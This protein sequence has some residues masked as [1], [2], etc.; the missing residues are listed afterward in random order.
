MPVSKLKKSDKIE[1]EDCPICYNAFHKEE[2]VYRPLLNG[3]LG[4]RYHKKCLEEWC[5]KSG[6]SCVD[7]VTTIKFNIL[8]SK[9]C[10]YSRSY[11]ITLHIENERIL[12]GTEPCDQFY[13][14]KKFISAQH[15]IPMEFMTLY[16]IKGNERIPVVESSFIGD[17]LELELAISANMDGFV[18]DDNFDYY[19][20]YDYYDKKD[21][22]KIEEIVKDLKEIETLENMKHLSPQ[23]ITTAAKQAVDIDESSPSF[24]IEESDFFSIENTTE[25]TIDFE[26]RESKE[27]IEEIDHTLSTLSPND[28]KR[29]QLEIIQSEEKNK[30]KKL[31]IKGI[32]MLYEN[33]KHVLSRFL[34]S[35]GDFITDPETHEQLQKF[36]FYVFSLVATGVYS[37][38]RL[39]ALLG[40][41]IVKFIP[42]IIIIYISERNE[43]QSDYPVRPEEPETENTQG[44]FSSLFSRN[45]GNKGHENDPEPSGGFFPKKIRKRTSSIV[46]TLLEGGVD[47]SEI[48]KG[49]ME[50]Y[51]FKQGLSFRHR[52]QS[53]RMRKRK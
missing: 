37:G 21:K 25:N 7:P 3:K 23:E 26:I 45:K 34:S 49:L 51:P 10:N 15:R 33:V 11:E 31:L 40:W 27:R 43:S 20:Y 6:Q 18:Y 12:L 1:I 17:D 38:L 5:K 44:F 42:K 8:N 28:P 13:D 2:I 19:D 24:S 30:Y 4:K 52:K 41:E 29:S 50:G 48:E 39:I 46:E 22:N 36:I 9:M 47:E 53:N 16:H 14:I 35:S 32:L